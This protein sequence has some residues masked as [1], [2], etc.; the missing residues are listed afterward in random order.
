MFDTEV[1]YLA[2]KYFYISLT[3]GEVGTTL[4]RCVAHSFC[5]KNN[6]F[7]IY[8]TVT[9]QHKYRSNCLSLLFLY[10]KNVQLEFLWSHRLRSSAHAGHSYDN[11][12]LSFL[13]LLLVSGCLPIAAHPDLTDFKHYSYTYLF[14]ETF[15]INRLPNISPHWM[16]I[17]SDIRL[18]DARDKC[19]VNTAHLHAP[20]YKYIQLCT[21]KHIYFHKKFKPENNILE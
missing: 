11:L 16:P 19:F 2:V 14:V 18:E 21:L 17:E 6:R 1:D 10:F 5:E 7:N 8:F 13:F 15:N 20:L 4:Y 9:M 3:F 12:L